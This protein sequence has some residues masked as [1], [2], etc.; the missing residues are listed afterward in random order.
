MSDLHDMGNVFT[1]PE[2]ERV[3]NLVEGI[4]IPEFWW[5]SIVEVESFNVVYNTLTPRS[6]LL[7]QI[8]NSSYV[9]KLILVALILRTVLLH[10]L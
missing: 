8:T 6:S 4:N 3:G 5:Y 1:D 10:L 7:T 9:I 2:L